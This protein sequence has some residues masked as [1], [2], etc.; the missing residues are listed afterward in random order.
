MP[1]AGALCACASSANAELRGLRSRTD[2]YPHCAL[3]AGVSISTQASVMRSSTSQT[4]MRGIPRSPNA[5]A[6]GSISQSGSTSTV[7]AW[8]SYRFARSR[9][10][11]GRLRRARRPRPGRLLLRGTIRHRHIRISGGTFEGDT[12]HARRAR[13]TGRPAL[14]RH[15][16][17]TALARRRA[18]RTRDGIEFALERAGTLAGARRP[19]ARLRRRRSRRGTVVF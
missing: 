1:R 13:R 11:P 7:R 16:T 2:P 17:P 14:R 19:L 6:V 10:A 4:T 9:A 8:N 18:R 15:A 3:R 12:S 5:R